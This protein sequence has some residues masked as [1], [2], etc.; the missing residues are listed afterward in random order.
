MFLIK[1]CNKKENDNKKQIFRDYCTK[2]TVL[3]KYLK[4]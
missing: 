4:I 3:L 1:R 2:R